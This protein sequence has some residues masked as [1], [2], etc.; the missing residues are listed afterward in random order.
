MPLG[1][2]GRNRQTTIRVRSMGNALNALRN[3]TPCGIFCWLRIRQMTYAPRGTS[4]LKKLAKNSPSEQEMHNTL[5]ALE[6]ENT[7]FA[8]YAI[9]I[10]GASYIERSIEISMKGRFVDLT[11]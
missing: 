2:E 8:D 9:A 3:T 10:I 5:H 11:D 7:P 1:F 4:R 6:V